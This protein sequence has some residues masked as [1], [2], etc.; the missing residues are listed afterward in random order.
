MTVRINDILDEVSAYVPDDEKRLIEKAYVFS[1]RVHQG[2]TRLSGEPYL[3]HPLEVAFMAGQMHLDATAVVASLLHDTIEDSLIPLEEIKAGFGEEVARVVDGL[4]K[5]SKM[6]FRSVEEQQAENFRKMILAMSKDLRVLLIKLIDRLH[7]MRTLE[8]HKR[9]AQIRIARETLDIYAPLANRLGIH[10]L[11]V[12]LEELSLKYLEPDDYKALK[13]KLDTIAKEKDEFIKEV[14]A[15]I[16][17]KINEAGIKAELKGRIKH[18]YSVYQKLKRQGISLE[19]IYDVLGVR[20][21]VTTVGECYET[22]GIIHSMWKPIQQRIKDFI[23]MPKP[24]KYQSLHTTVFGPDGERI[25]IQIR[26]F[27]MDFIANEGIAAHWLY[28]DYSKMKDQP[29]PR[30]QQGHELSWLRRLLESQKE[31]KDPHEFLQS[32]KLDLYPE[33][34]FVFTPRGEVLQFPLGATPLDF[35]YS[36][37]TQLGNQCSGAKVNGQI[38]KLNYELKSGDVIEILRSPKQHPSKDW[39]RIAKT[40]RARNKIQ[41]WL[42]TQERE[43]SISLGKEML[44]KKF[45][46]L[47]LS[48]DI[49]LEHLAKEF[50]FKTGEDLYASI[51]FGR[52]SVNQVIHKVM[53]EEQKKEHKEAAPKK[54]Q[55][56]SSVVVKGVENLL[57]RYAR[58]CRPI[59]GDEIIGF[60]TRGKGITVHRMNCPYADEIDAQRLIPVE[61][62][63]GISESHE[64]EFSVICED[65]PGMLGSITAILGLKNVNIT[66]LNATSLPDGHSKCVFRVLVKDLHELE[67]IATEIR[68]L[69]GVARI[70]RV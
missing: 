70:E 61:W 40:S 36:V 21:L 50:S 29:R 24:N 66:K 8:Y 32:V 13:N 47:H 5:I 41:T 26:T 2:Q 7:N 49:D 12:E 53:P 27:E 30:D 60:I 17:V 59:P 65:K 14:I 52:T 16:L 35:A 68:K 25:E 28:K 62:D 45:K 46:S 42:R 11:Q 54:K 56:G 18:I 3:N 67:K 69:K 55:V 63:S 38:V 48:K 64:I 51:G 44:E 10:W 39:L 19:N 9:E 31:L 4:T 15:Q 6:N 23:A 22:L 37:H 1:A 34:V 20:V 43:Q 33:D 57:V 58:C